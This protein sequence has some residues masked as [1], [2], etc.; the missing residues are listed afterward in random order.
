MSAYRRITG[1]VRVTEWLVVGTFVQECLKSV[2]KNRCRYIEIMGDCMRECIP[3]TRSFL[4]LALHFNDYFPGEP[5]L[6][7]ELTGASHIINV[8]AVTTASANISLATM[9]EVPQMW[10]ITV[11]Q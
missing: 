6:A 9:L 4:S 2:F 8:P 10:T 11:W 1:G 5:G 3:D 7:G